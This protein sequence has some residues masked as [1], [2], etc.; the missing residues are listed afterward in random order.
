[1]GG[2]RNPILQEQIL[3]SNHNKLQI[4]GGGQIK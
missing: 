4:Q 3:L 2:L 1:M